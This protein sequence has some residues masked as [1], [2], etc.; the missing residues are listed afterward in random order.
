MLLNVYNLKEEVLFTGTK[1][2]C[3]HFIKSRKLKRNEI[4]IKSSDSSHM[5]PEDALPIETTAPIESKPK[6]FFHKIFG[7]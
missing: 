5:G 2:D 1:Q 7:S 6:G 4:S 3:M